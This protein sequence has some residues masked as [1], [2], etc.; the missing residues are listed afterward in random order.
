MPNGVP[1]RLTVSLSF[2]VSTPSLLSSSTVQAIATHF[3]SSASLSD[4]R[5]LFILLVCFADFF[6]IDEIGNI[7]LR[8]VFIHS[9]H[10]SVY[11]PHSDHMSVYVRSYVIC[12]FMS[13]SPKTSSIGK[14][15]LLVL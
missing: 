14:A 2:R 15:R 11:V 10:M 5:F 9:D 13:L 8:D 1:T 4:L 3:A 12:Q 6:R 7:A